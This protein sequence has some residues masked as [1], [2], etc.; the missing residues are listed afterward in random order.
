MPGQTVS[1]GRNVSRLLDLSEVYGEF[2]PAKEYR[3]VLRMWEDLRNKEY[4]TCPL[5]LWG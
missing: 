2:D 3:V 4:Y 1:L 5:P